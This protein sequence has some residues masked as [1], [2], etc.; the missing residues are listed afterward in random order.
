MAIFE[1]AD[2]KDNVKRGRFRMRGR[3]LLLFFN[4]HKFV[5]G[6]WQGRHS[7]QFLRLP[8]SYKVKIC[9]S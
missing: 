1:G 9:R 2:S 5:L 6:N 3:D 4:S 7:S 8:K